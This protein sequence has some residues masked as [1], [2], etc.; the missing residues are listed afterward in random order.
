MDEL[1]IT[2]YDSELVKQLKRKIISL[3]SQLSIQQYRS[4]R[5]KGGKLLCAES[6]DFYCGEQHDFVLSVL[7]QVKVR[8]PEG[9]RPR[10]IIDSILSCNKPVGRGDEIL[11]EL[12][13]IFRKGNP[14]AEADISALRA[15]GFTF[16]PSKKHPKLR[17]HDRYMIVLPSTP[18]DSRRGALNSLTEISK[19]IA[20]SQKV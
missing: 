19:C 10:D 9:S 18:G 20:V 2:E 5:M 8:C 11:S 12:N 16:T 1:D 3:E 15:L 7:E 14:T 6:I 4:E 13:R 17:F